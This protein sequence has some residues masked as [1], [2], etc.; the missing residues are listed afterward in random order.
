MNTRPLW[1]IVGSSRAWR[2]DERFCELWVKRPGRETERLTSSN[3]EAD[4][5]GAVLPLRRL[6]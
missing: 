3:A 2:A 5:H 4:I 6:N 1:H